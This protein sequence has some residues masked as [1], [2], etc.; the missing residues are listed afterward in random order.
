MASWRFEPASFDFGVRLPAEGAT[1][2]AAFELK[3]TGEVSIAPELVSVSN[4]NGSG[5]AVANNG[6][7]MS[8]A[9]GAECTIQVT[10]DPGSGGKKEGKLA[11]ETAS[12]G[13]PA[14]TAQLRGSGGEPIVVIEPAALVF[15]PVLIPVGALPGGSKRTLTVKNAGSAD[16][17]IE[18]LGYEEV[19]A[20][21]GSR[22]NFFAGSSSVGPGL[23]LRAVIAPGGSCILNF[24]FSPR[25]PGTYSATLKLEDDASDSPQVVSLSGTAVA[26]PPTPPP[27]L[28]QRASWP[29]FS[30]KPPLRTKSRTATFAFTAAFSPGGFSCRSGKGQ[31][32]RPCTSPVHLRGLKPGFHV[33]SVRGVGTYGTPGPLLTYHW[34]ILG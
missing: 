2:A 7:F 32:L 25:D 15:D 28:P 6:C 5:F 17:S 10:F 20:V 21:P 29:K 16:L 26:A 31:P 1:S 19:G 11:V 24:E 3:N 23:C 8:L 22:P 9:P 4:Q 34:R 30:R 18:G 13:V 33:F 27:P 14:A 12:P